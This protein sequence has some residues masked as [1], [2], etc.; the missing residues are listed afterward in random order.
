MKTS[1]V[2]PIPNSPVRLTFW[3]CVIVGF[4]DNPTGSA[5]YIR[6]LGRCIC[7]LGSKFPTMHREETSELG[8]LEDTPMG[9]PRTTHRQFLMPNDE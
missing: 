4:P 9:N 7:K 3:R 5:S 8:T 6:P 2:F 1:P